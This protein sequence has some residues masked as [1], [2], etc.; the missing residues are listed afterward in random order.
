MS[1]VYL[2]FLMENNFVDG[3]TRIDDFVNP[4]FGVTVPTNPDSNGSYTIDIGTRN[5]GILN[6]DSFPGL[7][8]KNSP[9]FISRASFGFFGATQI[10]FFLQERST[11]RNQRWYG[12]SVGQFDLPIGPIIPPGWDFGVN[13]LSATQLVSGGVMT[14]E[15]LPLRDDQDVIEALQSPVTF[16]AI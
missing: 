8:D 4:P 5:L 10:E 3:T 14:I 12:P 11:L 1:V 2:R 16:S 7:S 13:D 15:L 6:L 9:L